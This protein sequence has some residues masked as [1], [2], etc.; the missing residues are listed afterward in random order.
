MI[1]SYLLIHLIF[2]DLSDFK[3]VCLSIDIVLLDNLST[4]Y[5][6]VLLGKLF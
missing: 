3:V 2:T 1:L 6:K 4:H 5:K